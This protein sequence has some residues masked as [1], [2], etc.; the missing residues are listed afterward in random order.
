MSDSGH[1]KQ[2]HIVPKLVTD[3]SRCDCSDCYGPPGDGKS[4]E[5]ASLKLDQEQV[6]VDQTAM[7]LDASAQR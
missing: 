4:Q 1:I 6:P 7:Q 5:P 3:H 2:T